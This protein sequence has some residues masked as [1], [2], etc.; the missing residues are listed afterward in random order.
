MF[1]EFS[2]DGETLHD[3][4][5]YRWRRA[6]NQDQLE[7]IALRL[8]R[9]SDDRRCVLQMWDVYQDLDREGKAIPCNLSATFQIDREG[10]L[11][12]NIF[13]RS[14]DIIWGAYGANAVHFSML[15][16][17]MAHWIGVPMGYMR[18]FSMN[19]HAYT[20]ILTAELF[21]QKC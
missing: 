15:M 3:A 1:S 8:K 12:M 11:D 19:W 14:N 6:F 5:G 10:R 21:Q 4:Y 16:E 7:K 13:N 9:N 2:D 20:A 17:Y 18:Q